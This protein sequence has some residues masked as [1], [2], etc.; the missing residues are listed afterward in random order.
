MQV[1]AKAFLLRPDTPPEGIPR[2]GGGEL[3]EPLASYAREAGLTMNRPPLTPYTRL[4][5]EATEHAKERGAFDPF[6]RAAYHA[7]WAEGVDLGDVQ[8]LVELGK[9]VGLDPEGLEEA[10]VERRYETQV[11]AQYKEAQGMGIQGIPSFLVGRYLFSG[12]QPYPLFQKVVRTALAEL[13][14]G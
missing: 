5:L 6:H 3:R 11:L 1:E 2:N 12:A 10:L 7:F 14:Q 13:E 9:Q 4:A 8:V